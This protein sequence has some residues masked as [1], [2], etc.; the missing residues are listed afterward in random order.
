MR[1][2]SGNLLLYALTLAVS[3]GVFFLIRFFGNSL[4]ASGAPE[5]RMV[6]NLKCIEKAWF[7]VPQFPRATAF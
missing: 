7:P 1:R 5:P 6:K 3:I 2:T 4:V